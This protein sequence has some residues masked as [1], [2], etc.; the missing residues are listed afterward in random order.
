MAIPWEK[1]GWIKTQNNPV[2]NNVTIAEIDAMAEKALKEYETKEQQETGE[3]EAALS[4][5]D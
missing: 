3:Q 2:E 1:V 4:T 5:A